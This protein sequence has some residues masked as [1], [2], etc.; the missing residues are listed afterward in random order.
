[1]CQLNPGSSGS[2]ESEDAAW[3]AGALDD[4]QRGGDQERAFGRQLIEIDQAGQ[5][6]LSA[7]M[8]DGVAREGGSKFEGL[9]GI[10][11]HPFGAPTDDV[12]LLREEGD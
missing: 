1:M 11:S 3:T 8:H 9:S 2:E 10:R 5:A 4:L 12:A 6:K 7:P